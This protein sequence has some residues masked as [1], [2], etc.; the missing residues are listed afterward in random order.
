MER[1][2]QERLKQCKIRICGENG[3][4]VARGYGADEK[5]GI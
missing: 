3:D 2:R 5:I 1:Y 4:L